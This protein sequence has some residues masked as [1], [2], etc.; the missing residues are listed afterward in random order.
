MLTACREIS[1]ALVKHFKYHLSSGKKSK[2]FQFEEKPD[3]YKVEN[4]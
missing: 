3:V 4:F 2:N 1:D